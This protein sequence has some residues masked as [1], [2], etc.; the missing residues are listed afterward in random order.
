MRLNTT[1]HTILASATL[2]LLVSGIPILPG[3]V[4]HEDRHHR[5]TSAPDTTDRDA[6]PGD[7]YALPHDPVTGEP[8]AEH[9]KHIVLL[10]DGREI[11]FVNEENA[12][13]FKANTRGYLRRIDQRMIEQQKPR[14]PL[15]T[16]PVSDE[17]VDH[18]GQPVD[19]VYRNR[20][21]RF[22]C[23]GCEAD[24]L[25]NPGPVIEK[26]DRAVIEAQKASYPAT[27]CPVTGMALGSMG[28]PVNVVV[29]NR[30]VR[31]CCDGCLSSFAENPQRI[32]EK[33]DAAAEASSDTKV[34]P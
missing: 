14:Y 32:F 29:A 7:P 11:R 24:F 1:C 30:L 33:L 26:L 12:E 13:L 15:D 5:P 18:E 21:V 23:V 28:E 16:C 10:H 3:A 27:A 34:T 9:D 20:L 31:F 17:P 25:A 8:L 22:C 2:V 4:A 19:V 6:W